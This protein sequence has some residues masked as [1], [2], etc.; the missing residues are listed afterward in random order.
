MSLIL[1]IYSMEQ[2]LRYRS[3]LIVNK[4]GKVPFWSN[5]TRNKSDILFSLLKVDKI[6]SLTSQ[7][8]LWQE[9][10]LQSRFLRALIWAERKRTL[11]RKFSFQT[12][13]MHKALKELVDVHADKMDKLAKEL[14]DVHDDKMDKL[15]KELEDIHDG[16]MEKALK[17]LED[18]HNEKMDKLG[19]ATVREGL[20]NAE[21]RDWSSG[22]LE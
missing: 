20:R 17:K 5:A 13:D 6:S 19:L 2:I 8:I 7:S 22:V 15:A 14:E 21:K 9:S 18:V 11:N 1:S 3:C 10:V 4:L 12:R 16:K